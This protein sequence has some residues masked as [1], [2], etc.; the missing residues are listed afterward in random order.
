LLGFGN[1]N[2][3]AVK[4]TKVQLAWR[5]RQIV[6]VRVAGQFESARRIGDAFP[7]GQ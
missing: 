1:E 3:T 5:I 6:F 4:W 7:D 2:L